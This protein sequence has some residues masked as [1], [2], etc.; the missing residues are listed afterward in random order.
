MGV[1]AL[2]LRLLHDAGD[3]ALVESG[4]ESLESGELLGEKLGVAAEELG[5]SADGLS[6]LLLGHGYCRLGW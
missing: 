4:Q 6:D 3:G 1:E 5:D 2:S